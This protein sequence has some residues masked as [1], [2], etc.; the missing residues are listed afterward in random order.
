MGRRNGEDR[1][2]KGRAA[3]HESNEL[4][5]FLSSSSSPRETSRDPIETNTTKPSSPSPAI[6]HLPPLLMSPPSPPVLPAH[7]ANSTCS[8]FRNPW[9]SSLPPTWSELLSAPFPL[10]LTS[11]SLHTHAHARQLKVVSPAWLT[12]KGKERE[13]GE[14]GVEVTWLGHASSFLRI[15]LPSSSERT[16]N[17]LLDPIFSFRAGPQPGGVS[18]GP[19]RRLE[20][21]CQVGELP[22]VDLVCISHNQ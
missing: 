17:V 10:S 1:R 7:H 13:V 15:S 3:L 16:V 12:D 21:P 14:G 11:S 5:L 4:Q 9:P 6:R 18:V 22:R 8:S 2:R 20:S 19:S